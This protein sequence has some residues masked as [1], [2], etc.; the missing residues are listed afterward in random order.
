MLSIVAVDKA[1]FLISESVTVLEMEQDVSPASYAINMSRWR[2]FTLRRRNE[3]INFKHRGKTR[4]RSTHPSG[5]ECEYLIIMVE[6]VS[7]SSDIACY[8]LIPQQVRQCLITPFFS[9]ASLTRPCKYINRIRWSAPFCILIGG[10]SHKLIELRRFFEI[11]I[12]ITVVI[13]C[14]NITCRS[15]RDMLIAKETMS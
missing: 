3:E 8:G 2:N 10:L 1:N 6:V 7:L 4:S 9:D 12:S 11:D 14:R 13:L 15:T 5:M